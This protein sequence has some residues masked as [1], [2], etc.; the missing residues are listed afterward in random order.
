MTGELILG[1]KKKKKTEIKMDRARNDCSFS[2]NPVTSVNGRCGKG[3]RKVGRQVEQ[4][5]E[6]KK[7]RQ[8]WREEV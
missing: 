2:D 7:G 1:K 8:R 3:R 4:G 5:E 6:M